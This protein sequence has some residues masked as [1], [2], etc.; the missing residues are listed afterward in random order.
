[1]KDKLIMSGLIG[2]NLIVWSTIVS[3]ISQIA[4]KMIL[5]SMVGP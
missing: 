3:E 5:A 4:I 2:I 1:M